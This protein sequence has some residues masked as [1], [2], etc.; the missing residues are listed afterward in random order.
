MVARKNDD[1]SGDKQVRQCS[2]RPPLSEER[3]RRIF[4]LLEMR[5]G[6]APKNWRNIIK[7]G[8]VSLLYGNTQLP[9]SDERDNCDGENNQDSEEVAAEALLGLKAR[10][11]KMGPNITPFAKN[12]NNHNKEVG[13]EFSA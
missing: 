8:G 10:A 3:L 12:N 1:H 2:A 13:L 4:M 11:G 9:S 6:R 7:R 5:G